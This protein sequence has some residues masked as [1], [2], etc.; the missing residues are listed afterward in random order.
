MK[1]FFLL[2]LISLLFTFTSLAQNTGTITGTITSQINGSPLTG[3]S[4]EIT[5]LRRTA[6][7]DN[8]G[9]F[10]F[11]GLAAGR[12]TLVT[13]IEGFSDQT[14][15]VTVA[16]GAASTANFV[17]SL[18]SLREE[19]TVTASGTEESVFESFQ[20]VNSVGSTRIRE[21]ASTG[22]GE[23]LERESGVG[24]RSFGPGTSRPV[25]RGFDGDRVLVVQDGVRNG[26]LA[27]QSGDHGEP[28]DTLN[29]ERLEVIKGP[30]TLLYGSNAIGGVVNAVTSDEEQPHKGLRG[31]F[32]GLGAT[33]NRQGG[34]SGGVEYGWDNLLFNINGN[35]L[36]EGD[37]STPLGRIPNSASQGD[38]GSTSLGYYGRK[39]FLKGSFTGDRRRYGT[40]YSPL[41][42]AGVLLT[43]SNGNP[44]DVKLQKDCQYDIFQI[45][46]RFANQL[47]DTPDEEIDIKMRRNNFR[48]R[49]G[50]RE[51]GGWLERGNFSIDYTRYKHDEIETGPTG[52]DEIA[53]SFF[54]NVLSYRAVFQQA[55]RGILT[56]QFGFEGYGRDYLTEGA[57]QLIDGRVR[58]NNFA[59][60]GLQELAFERVAL[61]FGARVESNRYR[62]ENTTLYEARTFTGL[63]GAAAARVRLWDGA[64]FIANFTSAYRSPSLEE[65]YNEGPHIGTV[66][67]EVGDQNLRRERSNGIEFSLRQRIRRVRLNGSAFH[68]RIDNFIFLAP[69][70]TDGDGSVEVED[71]L[72]V[73]NYVQG[74][75]TFTG[76]DVTFDADIN[77]WMGLFVVADVVKAELRNGGIPLPR[78]TPPR[79]RVGLDL[80]YKGL[81]VRPEA[82]FTGARK[83][84]DVFSLE[85]P[86]AGHGLFNVNASYTIARKQTAHTFSVSSSNLGNR[87]YRNHLSFIKDLAPEPGRGFRFS[88]TVRLF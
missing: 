57:E 7:T 33:N 19:V 11:T 58:Q 77:D 42:E 39:G 12:Y 3:V 65:L 82:V 79:V 69:Q 88:Y 18:N 76:A 38:G 36:R 75:A 31:N 72:P 47:P 67:F 43:D 27:S 63:S 16:A 34:V 55:K 66:T 71:N 13:H 48:L 70:D 59:F 78:I 49:G 4:I 41:F 17:V 44:C 24:K 52:V 84:G 53:T 15:S 23:I 37:Y 62:P 28:I 14:T 22:I 6:E 81:S 1:R 68:Y 20:S 46:D 80:R 25:I 60:F 8:S 61:Q 2:S 5:Q 30:A 10:E 51:V 54:N 56:G 64:S 86:T 74:T 87:L 83:L 26:S 50:F 35:F 45:Q 9:K 85:T 73:G 32:T 21:L 29:L 40:P